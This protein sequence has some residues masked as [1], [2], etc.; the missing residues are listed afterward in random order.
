MPVE[1]RGLGS[2]P[3][4]NAGKDRRLGNLAT[5]VSVQKLRTALHAKA[6]EEPGFRFYTLY[7]KIHRMDVLEHAYA[8][9]R[10]LSLAALAPEKISSPC[11][12]AS[13]LITPTMSLPASSIVKDTRPPPASAS[14]PIKSAACVA[15]ET[16]LDSLRQRNH[17][18]E[19]WR[20]FAKQRKCWVSTLPLS[21]AGSMMVS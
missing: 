17:P 3:A 7:D 2:E 1:G 9:C 12:R 21:I 10:A 4:S 16:S 13:L 6:K 8:C 19:N 5:P 18:Q 14:P 11:F 15:I 20:R